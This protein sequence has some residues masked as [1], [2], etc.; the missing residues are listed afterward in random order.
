MRS[1]YIVSLTLA[2]VA[3]GC[4]TL[5]T[6]AVGAE[7]CDTWGGVDGVILAVDLGS[8]GDADRQPAARQDSLVILDPSQGHPLI[9]APGDTFYFLMRVPPGLTGS[10]PVRLVHALV[11]QISYEVPMHTPMSR[12]GGRVASAVLRVPEA[13]QPGLYDLKLETQLGAFWARRSVKVVQAFKHRFRF[14]HLSDM[15]VGDLTA[16]DFDWTVPTEV[17]MLNPEFI[18]ATGDYT[19]WSR[20]RDDPSWWPRVLEYFRRFNAPVYMICGEHDHEDSF[21]RYVASSL[22]GTVDYGDYHGVLLRDHFANRIDQDRDQL[23]WLLGDL[24]A[25]RN[26]VFNFIVTHNDEL[27]LLE[28]LRGTGSP[29]DLVKRYKLKMI[30]CGGHTDWQGR[31]FA[32]RLAGF[33]GLH[34]IRTHQSS[35]CMRDKATGVSHYRVIEVDGDQVQY[36][37][38]DDQGDGITQH[39]IPAGRLRVFYN[40]MDQTGKLGPPAKN[41]GS[42]RLVVATAQNG[43]NQAFEDCRVWLRV[44]KGVTSSTSTG[45]QAASGTR[46]RSGT[47]DAGDSQDQPV[48]GNGRLVQVLD[49][50]DHWLCEIA[51]DLPDKSAVRVV[52]LTAGEVPKAVPLSVSL[53]GPTELTFERKQTRFG[54]V[55]YASNDSLA[56]ELTNQTDQPVECWPVVRLNGTQVE[57]D[58]QAIGGRWP[59]AVPAKQTIALPLKLT[60][61]QMSKG[62]HLLQVYF[63]DDPLARLSTFGVSLKGG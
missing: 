56:V 8:P 1:I 2:L 36:V 4:R 41:D 28:H 11:R 17:N 19:Q 44:A 32:S 25:N 46:D 7:L 15:N 24:D 3:A 39:S 23:R 51:I 47:G 52:A 10:V 38:P 9:L 35:T 60:L 49:A 61:G 59:V 34:Y 5:E 22:V 20:Q 40:V 62:Q 57:V 18:V 14:V 12:A 37:Y 43:L 63:L 30:I 55:Y 31:E 53:L 21:T 45:G 50:T 48:V 42:E 29:A 6:Q 33:D 16:P 54:L 58:R 26:K 27:D 13:V